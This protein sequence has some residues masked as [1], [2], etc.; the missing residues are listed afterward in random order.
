MGISL[1]LNCASCPPLVYLVAPEL[2]FH[3]TTDVLLRFLCAEMEVVRVGLA[4]GWRHG[5]RVVNRR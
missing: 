2:R 4:E 1:A 5:L 3:K